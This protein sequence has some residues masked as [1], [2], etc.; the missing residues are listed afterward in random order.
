MGADRG[1][2]GMDTHTLAVADDTKLSFAALQQMEYSGYPVC[3]TLVGILC[4]AQA[5]I[6]VSLSATAL[7]M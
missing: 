4:F 2:K 5:S 6:T 7:L 1:S 3:D